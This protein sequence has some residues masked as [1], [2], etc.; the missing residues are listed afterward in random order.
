MGDSMMMDAPWSAKGGRTSVTLIK[1]LPSRSELLSRPPWSLQRATHDV[2]AC[3][4]RL[5]SW[6]RKLVLLA[7][8]YPENFDPITGA[9][10]LAR[11][12][13]GGELPNE[14]ERDLVLAALMYPFD[15]DEAESKLYF[16]SYKPLRNLNLALPFR[17]ST[18]Q[19][20]PS[21]KN[22]TQTAAMPSRQ[23]KTPYLRFIPDSPRSYSA[24]DAFHFHNLKKRILSNAHACYAH[25]F[26]KADRFDL[27][28][29]STTPTG[30]LG[31]VEFRCAL[32]SRMRPARSST[33][34]KRI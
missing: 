3:G 28:T 10:S 4:E 8:R 15:L 26:P 1:S 34:L 11:T 25:R 2:L 24:E 5:T 21:G 13:R 31:S 23:K 9:F 17:P 20:S 18:N 12:A 7:S 19:G 29:S 16:A 33:G 30:H 32:I 27:I 22:P 14:W 6:E